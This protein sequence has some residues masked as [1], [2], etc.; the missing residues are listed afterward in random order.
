M[1]V[2]LLIIDMNNKMEEVD[3][4]ERGREQLFMGSLPGRCDVIIQAPLVSRVHGCFWQQGDTFFYQDWESTCGTY[5]EQVDGSQMYLKDSSKRVPLHHG[6]IL[7]IALPERGDLGSLLLLFQQ[8]KEEGFWRRYPLIA[9]DTLVGR[10]SRCDI[11]VL[12][13]GISRCHA[14]VCR[15]GSQIFIRDLG[16]TNGVFVNHSRI[17]KETPLQDKDVISLFGHILFY[18]GEA[19]IYRM[20]TGYENHFTPFGKRPSTT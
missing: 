10:S 8:D 15:R 14:M 4:G 3:I 13:E 6:D 1:R 7:R 5:V 20:K 11:Q 19:L 18:G 12:G 16:S 9:R 17:T 2:S